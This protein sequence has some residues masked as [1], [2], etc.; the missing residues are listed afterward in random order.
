MSRQRDLVQEI[1]ETR[2]RNKAGAAKGELYIRL[3]ALERAF[4]NRATTNEEL[5]RYF[6]IALVACI[7]SYF[8]T[9]IKELI[10]SGDPYVNN[11]GKLAEKLKF[12]YDIVK[13]FQGKK[14]SLGE[15]VSHMVSI[16]N[17]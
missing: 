1:I 11:A 12:D 17:L 2:E 7:E 3:I 5:I 14:I 16:N 15:F 13:A 6:P 9:T 4:E 8:R 10:D